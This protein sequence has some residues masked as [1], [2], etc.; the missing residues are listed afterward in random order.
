MLVFGQ[1]P[2]GSLSFNGSSSYGVFDGDLKGMRTVSFWFRLRS[3]HDSTSANHQAFIVRDM[4]YPNIFEGEEFSIYLASHTDDAPGRMVFECNSDAVQAKIASDRNSWQ[5]DRWYH[6]AVVI[7]PY[8]GLQMYVNG[9]LQQQENP[10]IKEVYYRSEGRGSDFHLGKW[11]DISGHYLKG[12]LEELKIWNSVRTDAEI[13]N[14]M[15]RLAP[16]SS[17]G[18]LID[19]YSFNGNS[20]LSMSS[21][22]PGGSVVHLN[23][24]VSNDLKDSDAPIGE[25]STHSY[26]QD[27]TVLSFGMNENYELIID[28]I[29]ALKEMPRALHIYYIKGSKN[30]LIAK[31]GWFGVW[32]DEENIQFNAT[33]DYKGLDQ[34]C[35]SCA[36]IYTRL[37]RLQKWKDRN[38]YPQTCQFEFL[39]ENK[40]NSGVNNR[41][42]FAVIDTLNIG[43]GVGDTLKA[44]ATDFIEL[45]ARNYPGATY[46]WD[47]SVS[48]RTIYVNSPG[49]HKIKVSYHGCVALDSVYVDYTKPPIFSLPNDTSICKGDTLWLTAPID[50]A[51]YTWAGGLSHYRRFAITNKGTYPLKIT[52]DGCSFEDEITISII[53][54]FQIDLG[55]DTELCLGESIKYKF[56]HPDVKYRWHDGD[57]NSSRTIFNE[58]GTFWL[59][60]WNSCFTRVDTIHVTYEECECRLFMPNAFTPNDDD[61]NDYFL[62]VTD[63]YYDDFELEIVDRWGSFV[64]KTSDAKKGWDGTVNGGPAPQGAYI[65]RMR[66]K[67]YSWMSNTKYEYGRVNLIR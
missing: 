38:L 52:K 5:G 51:E 4:G 24:F 58:E 15:C 28:S 47:D 66:Y 62:P 2:E 30:E 64:F 37:N 10:I 63:C 6:L 34:N 11:G 12:E 9:H 33:I 61:L 56:N 49:M 29:V 60:A 65:W 55:Y 43:L 42:E 54:S 8:Q 26:A 13:R 59:T 57:T 20:T 53:P 36:F 40:N 23:N 18:S 32:F 31:K 16:S 44:C 19:Y 41:E 48:N 67:K 21:N 39:K 3:Y 46:L 35:D 50:S 17:F 1:V 27:L 22:V 14:N 7:N 25:K 45:S